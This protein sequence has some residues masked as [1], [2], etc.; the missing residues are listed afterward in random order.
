MKRRD[1]IKSTTFVPASLV[2][3]KDFSGS[4]N[5]DENLKNSVSFSEGKKL[6]KPSDVK[7]NVKPIFADRI[8]AAAYGGPCRW[9]PL[10]EMTPEYAM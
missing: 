8:H 9:Y 6:P 7:L 2:I 5:H 1:F 10:N 4:G 3:A